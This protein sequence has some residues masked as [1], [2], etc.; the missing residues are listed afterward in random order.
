MILQNVDRK[1]MNRICIFVCGLAGVVLSSCAT[2]SFSEYKGV[3]R[4]K[5]YDFYSAQLPD[6]F[7]GF[8]IAFASDFHYESRFTARRLPGAV[9]ALQ[10]ADADV[11]LLGGDYR[12]RD[13]GDVDE[14]FPDLIEAGL[15]CFN[16]FQ[17]E[18]MDVYDILPKY[19][20]RL[21]FHGGLSM[22]KTLPFGTKQEV[23]E[24]SERLLELGRD[25]GYIF[26]PSHSVESDTSLENMLA[27]INV[28]QNQLK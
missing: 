27:F 21:A 19:R 17:P 16:P 1:I 22:Q 23:I 4:V 15:N 13:G 5:R 11:L 28:A 2:A 24:E 14:L 3:G 10:S 12:G 7:D 9:R 25:G 8:R 18:V 26:S 20:G 6:S